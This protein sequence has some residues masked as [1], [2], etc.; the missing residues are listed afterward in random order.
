MGKLK[1]GPDFQWM[2]ANAEGQVPPGSADVTRFG[3]EVVTVQSLPEAVRSIL[4][5]ADEGSFVLYRQEEKY[6]HV[7]NVEKRI[8]SRAQP[9]EEA[10]NVVSRQMYK[11]KLDRAL[12]EWTERLKS[13]YRA[14]VYAVEF[15]GS[16]P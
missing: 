9:F 13:A 11:E 16:A 8:R 15:S 14:K 2:K 10:Q 3:E 5:N 12:A 4:E 7:L 6:F 1:S